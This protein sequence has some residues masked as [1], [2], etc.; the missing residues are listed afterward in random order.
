M[1]MAENVDAMFR[2]FADFTR[3]RILHLLAQRPLCVSEI[4]A[5][6]GAPQPKVSRHLGYLRA[7]GLVDD[8]Q[9]GKWR[10]YS[11]AAP[12]TRFQARI[13]GCLKECNEDVG[14]LRRDLKRLEKALSGR[15]GLVAEALGP[16]A[17]GKAEPRASARGSGPCPA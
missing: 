5:A 1:D 11:L 8:R 9:V 14:V 4:M 13:F 7:S 16:S 15:A 6:I 2:A 3:L 17:A 12:T 10:C